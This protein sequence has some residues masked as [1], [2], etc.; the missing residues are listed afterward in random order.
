M[1]HIKTLDSF[2]TFAVLVVIIGHWVHLPNIDVYNKIPLGAIGVTMFFVLSG[3]LITTI[4]L[5]GR[6]RVLQKK[7]GISHVLKTFYIRRTLRIFPVYYLFILLLFCFFPKVFNDF[8]GSLYWCIFYISNIYSYIHQH[9]IGYV[10]H[11]W[12]LAVE[13]QFYLLWPAVILFTPSKKLMGVMIA[14]IIG[15]VAIKL[16]HEVFVPEESLTG[17]YLVLTPTCF[18]AFG[19]GGI[20]ALF[21]YEH[22]HYAVFCKW[23]KRLTIVAIPLFILA[24]TNSFIS[25]VFLRLSLSIPS[26]ALIIIL[27][28]GKPGFITRVFSNRVLT[29]LGKISYGLYLWHMPI[30]AVYPVLSS[31]LAKNGLLIPFTKYCILP[32]VGGNK[33]A[34]IYFMVLVI[35]SSI[36][37][38]FFEKPINDFKENFDYKR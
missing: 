22:I 26:A 9:F 5:G 19:I 31:Y 33:Q 28:D 24:C 2:R 3:F 29:Y 21:K 16:T 4:L 38:F 7:A 6:E 36:S 17:M 35:I 18:D 30:P 27:M 11:L 8:P 12:S 32:F 37:W 34:L 10:G 23:M 1:R 25:N 13:E 15:T 14:F 20:L